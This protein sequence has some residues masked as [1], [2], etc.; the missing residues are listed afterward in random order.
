MDLEILKKKIS[1]Y[2]GE[3]GR[4]QNV[5]DDLLGEILFAWET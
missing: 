2:R 1:T 3:G 4:V 5:S